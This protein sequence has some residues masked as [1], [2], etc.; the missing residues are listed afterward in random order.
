MAKS[1]NV[2]PLWHDFRFIMSSIH[3]RHEDPSNEESVCRREPCEYRGDKRQSGTLEV[4]K[5]GS[6]WV[7]RG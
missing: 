6:V 4:E 3:R 2:L 5:E 7:R 1:T